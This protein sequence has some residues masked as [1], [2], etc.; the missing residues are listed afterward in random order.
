MPSIL[1]HIEWYIY[2]ASVELTNASRATRRNTNPNEFEK[3]HPAANEMGALTF[4][5]NISTQR[6]T[7]H[8]DQPPIINAIVENCH[9][10]LAI[11]T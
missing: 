2:L 5:R 7:H 10:H 8:K 9:A 1:N 4:K 11:V 6:R 3:Q